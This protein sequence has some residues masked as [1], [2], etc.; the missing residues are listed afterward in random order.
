LRSRVGSGTIRDPFIGRTADGTYHLL[1]TDGWHSTSIVHSS[2]PDLLDWTEP[3]LLPVMVQIPGAGNAWAPE[4]VQVSDGLVHIFWSSILGEA[5]DPEQWPTTPQEQRI[6]T[7]TTRDFSSVGEASV[8]FDPGYSVIDATVVA[9]PVRGGYLM[10]FKDERGPN[11]GEGVHKRISLARLEK[12]G[13][14]IS[15]VSAPVSAWPVEG[16]ALYRR[17]EH[18]VMIFDHFLDGYYGAVESVD[19][20]QWSRTDLLVPEGMRHASVLAVDDATLKNVMTRVRGVKS[21]GN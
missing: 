4:F 5:A 6:W 8:F 13:S 2:S 16:P 19:G 11:P 10:A 21:G 3:H 15:A 1:A 20:E 14:A 12:L 17:G 18:W 9:D 7:T